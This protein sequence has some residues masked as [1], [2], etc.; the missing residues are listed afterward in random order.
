MSPAQRCKRALVCIILELARIYG[1]AVALGRDDADDAVNKAFR[2]VL[3]KAHPD[4]GGDA[5]HMQ[6]LN[7]A[8]EQWLQAKQ[9]QGRRGRPSQ[10]RSGAAAPAPPAAASPA[11]PAAISRGAYRVRGQ[12]IMLTYQGFPDVATWAIFVAFIEDH[13]RPWL[14]LGPTYIRCNQFCI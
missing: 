9:N 14:V 7:A 1:L 3:L 4:K 10:A 13:K 11:A 12:S 6:R 2:R 5:N 8:R